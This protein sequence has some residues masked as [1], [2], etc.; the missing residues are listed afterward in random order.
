MTKD[1]LRALLAT[2]VPEAIADGRAYRLN[3]VGSGN[4]GDAAFA[5]RGEPSTTLQVDFRRPAIK[6]LDKFTQRPYRTFK[7]HA[8]VRATDAANPL[9][10][11][12]HTYP[13]DTKL[14]PAFFCHICDC[15]G[16][17]CTC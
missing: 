16:A 4:V 9:E 17:D 5:V 2:I 13:S 3:R 7:P 8:D 10:F 6:R 11:S 14:T 1:Q 12:D 15:T